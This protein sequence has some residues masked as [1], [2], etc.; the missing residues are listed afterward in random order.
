MRIFFLKVP[1]RLCISD[2][3]VVISSVNKNCLILSS[4]SWRDY[5]AWCR[6][7]ILTRSRYEYLKPGYEVG[8]LRKIVI[9]RKKGGQQKICMGV[10]WG[11]HLNPDLFWKHRFGSENHIF[12]V[13]NNAYENNFFFYWIKPTQST[14]WKYSCSY[15][16]LKSCWKMVR[17]IGS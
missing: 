14:Y 6:D 8:S 1:R 4:V 13:K 5:C 9:T 11:F 10:L 16:L 3:G 7:R 12:R 2:F 15:F 17:T